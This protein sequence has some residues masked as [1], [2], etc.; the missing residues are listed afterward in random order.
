M[1][2]GLSKKLKELRVRGGLTQEGL[3]RVSNLT[4]STIA[5]LEGGRATS[6]DWY[7]IVAIAHALGVSV[8]EFDVPDDEA[9]ATPEKKPTKKRR[10]P[11]K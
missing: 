6:P 10:K 1:A 5:K 3:A 2:S 4:T 9:D 7:T 11:E 8:A